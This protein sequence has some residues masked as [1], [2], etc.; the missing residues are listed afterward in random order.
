MMETRLGIQWRHPNVGTRLCCKTTI[1]RS[2]GPMR[3]TRH[4]D[5]WQQIHKQRFATT[6]LGT[7]TSSDLFLWIS[8]PLERPFSQSPHCHCRPLQFG[9]T[10]KRS[11]VCSGHVVQQ[12]AGSHLCQPRQRHREICRHSTLVGWRGLEVERTECDPGLEKGSW[13]TRGVFDGKITRTR[14]HRIAHRIAHCHLP[15]QK[16]V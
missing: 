6:I 11:G 14:S 3:P 2:C 7:S 4:L 13:R 12:S 9:K 15:S 8:L 5:N 16:L 10:G 1:M